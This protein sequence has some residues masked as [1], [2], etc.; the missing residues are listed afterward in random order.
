M[1]LLSH[2]DCLPA[3]TYTSLDYFSMQE[4]ATDEDNVDVIDSG[5]LDVRWLADNAPHI[6]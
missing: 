4:E 2:G 5:K 3:A 1:E 6:N